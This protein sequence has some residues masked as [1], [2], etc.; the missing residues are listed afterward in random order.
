MI[1]LRPRADEGGGGGGGDPDLARGVWDGRFWREISSKGFGGIHLRE[2][3]T[4]TF[5]NGRR[6]EG[7]D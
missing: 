6:T 1:E 2:T 4:G 5:D 3:T 7:K